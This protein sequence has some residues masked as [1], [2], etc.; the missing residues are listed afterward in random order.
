MLQRRRPQQTPCPAPTADN[1]F[2]AGY[3]DFAGRRAPAARKGRRPA[4]SVFCFVYQVAKF[5]RRL[6]VLIPDADELGKFTV[7]HKS[8]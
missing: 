1:R 3:C 6:I 8:A 4:Q 7:S 2:L 5:D